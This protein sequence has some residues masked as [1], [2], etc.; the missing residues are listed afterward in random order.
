MPN[1]T[2]DKS[3]LHF[4]NVRSMMSTKKLSDHAKAEV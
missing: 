3:L 2:M 1:N 4:V